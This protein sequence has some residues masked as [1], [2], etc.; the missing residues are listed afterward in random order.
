MT[1]RFLIAFR[2]L[3]RNPRRTV[4]N[5]VMISSGMAAIIV[6]KGFTANLLIKIQTVQIDN[7]FG[8]LQLASE[9]MWQQS[10]D[11]SPKARLTEFDPGFLAQINKIPG[12]V[13]TSGRISFA[14]LIS[15]ADRSTSAM[16]VSFDP[17]REPQMRDHLKILQGRNFSKGAS[18][19]VLLG[20]GLMGQL[21][22][23]VGD[24]LTILSYTFDGA[25]NAM[26]VEFVGQFSTGGSEIDESAFFIPLATAQKLLDTKAVQQLVVRLDK[27][28]ET[29]R[30]MKTVEQILPAGIGVRSWEQ[31]AHF[32]VQIVN[33]TNVQNFIIE[34][35]IL[36]LGLLAIANTVGQSVTER[37][38]EIG[39][40]RAIGDSRFEIIYQFLLEGVLLGISGGILGCIF[41]IAAAALVT[42]L[43]IPIYPPGASFPIPIEVDLVP[44]V[45]RDSFLLTC[46]TALIATIIPAMRASRLNIVEALRRNI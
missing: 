11:D 17:D 44:S 26:D 39:T 14:G 18:F 28:E 23:K 19:E 25:V 27:T 31:L 1:M 4:L 45:F 3:W 36:L 6:F 32:Y 29:S 34:W 7:Q 5:L 30:V 35:I 10:A 2:N 41:G 13:S 24:Q 42:S 22:A 38:G 16:G 12:V 46:M 33:F 37:I 43:K 15:N 8:H 21:G 40:V 20:S 9:K